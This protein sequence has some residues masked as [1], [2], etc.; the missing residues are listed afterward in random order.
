MKSRILLAAPAVFSLAV[1]ACSAEVGSSTDSTE[2]TGATAEAVSCGAVWT[3]CGGQGWSGATCCA[4]GSTCTISNPYYSQC[5]PGSGGNNSNCP[6]VGAQDT[7]MRAAA[8]AAFQIMKAASGDCGGQALGPCWGSSVLSSQHYRVAASGTTIEFDPSGPLYYTAATTPAQAALAIAQL[9]PTV[10]SFLVAALKWDQANTNGALFAALPPTAALRSFTYPGNNTGLSIADFNAASRT[11]VVTG[12]NWCGTERVHFI[13]TAS[14]ENGFAPAE[15]Q[16]WTTQFSKN[17]ES[18]KYKG[19]GNYPSTPFNGAGT[20]NPYLVVSVNGAAL[21][22]NSSSW[23]TQNC[24]N[25]SSC[26]GTLDIDPI[27]YAQPGAYYDANGNLVGPQA[28]PFAL[29]ITN[30]Y[31]DPGHQGQW[32]TRTVSGVQQWGTFTTAVNV[33][34]TTVYQYVKQ[35]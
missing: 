21:N 29:V 1:L 2:S 8:T 5:L 26:N 13:D 35:M 33:L 6:S 12:S 22:W 7:Q 3:Q 23:P 16:T 15:I 9:D 14:K 20:A 31:A 25:D 34:G 19:S 28:N 4:A 24:P 17:P 30:L 27:P 32:A 10:A 18:S 11:E